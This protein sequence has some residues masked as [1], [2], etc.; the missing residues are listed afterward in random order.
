MQTIDTIKATAIQ[1]LSDPSRKFGRAGFHTL[2]DVIGLALVKA[3][4]SAPLASED[5]EKA[6]CEIVQSFREG[7]AC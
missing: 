2:H 7:R 4:E 5:F 6:R 1:L 3:S